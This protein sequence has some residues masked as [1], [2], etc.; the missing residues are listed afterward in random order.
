MQDCLEDWAIG[1]VRGRIIGVGW[2][3]GTARGHHLCL[4]D[5]IF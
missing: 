2:V 4:T 3:R 5:T 1:R